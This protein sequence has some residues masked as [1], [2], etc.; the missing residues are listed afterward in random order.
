M[1][2]NIDLTLKRDFDNTETQPLFDL[3]SRDL[4]M[5]FGNKTRVPW[6]LGNRLTVINSNQDLIKNSET[7]SNNVIIFGNKSRRKEIKYKIWMNSNICDCCGKTLDKF[8]WKIK[9]GLCD[10]CDN[11]HYKKDKIIWRNNITKIKEEKLNRI[12]WR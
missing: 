2:R 11:F 7:I 4:A 3:I 10:D 6:K 1:K 5:R 8:P 9:Y 12:C